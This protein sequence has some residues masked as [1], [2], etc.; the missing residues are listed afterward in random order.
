ME[1]FSWEIFIFLA[2]V[3]KCNE[4]PERHNLGHHQ[5]F[6]NCLFFI[7]QICIKFLLCPFLCK[8]ISL[9]EREILSQGVHS[10]ARRKDAHMETEVWE[11]RPSFGLWPQMFIDTT[12]RVPGS[13]L[14]WHSALELGFQLW[15]SACFRPLPCPACCWLES[16][17]NCAKDGRCPLAW[18]P[19]GRADGVKEIFIF[20]HFVLKQSSEWYCLLGSWC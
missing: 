9:K 19:C 14:R 10:C 13:C 1:G 5:L 11:R 3:M 18:V 7:L 20:G 12:L 15:P 8:R 16:S 2:Y 17:E 4:D 6:Y